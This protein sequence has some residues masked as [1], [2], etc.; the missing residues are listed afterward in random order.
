MTKL[1]IVSDL[2]LE[3]A[4]TT[5]ENASDTDIL[6]LSGDICVANFDWETYI[7]FFEQ[8]SRDFPHVIYVLGNHEHYHGQFFNTYSLL[9]IQL[10]HLRNIHILD[11]EGIELE[12][13][14]FFGTTLWTDFNRGDF[15]AQLCVQNSLNDYV[16]IRAGDFRLN[17]FL[18]QSYHRNALRLI[19]AAQ[20]DVVIGHHAPS[21]K[22]ISP[23]YQSAGLINYGYY[24]DLERFIES[25][26]NIRLWTHGHV[27]SSHDYTLGETRIVCNPRGYCK[28]SH[29]PE[30]PQFNSQKVI[31]L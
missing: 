5:I 11:N 19:N 7:P 31:E 26:D 9:K 18:T 29:T 6:V 10:E 3:F 13:V 14:R 27:H 25:N 17:P 2:H 20:P 4:T 24:S 1:Q 21:W 16:Y 12:H 22:S 8:V 28:L 30:N 15:A 23:Q